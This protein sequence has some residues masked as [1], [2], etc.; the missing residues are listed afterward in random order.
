[1][2]VRRSLRDL[3]TLTKKLKNRSPEL[4]QVSLHASHLPADDEI[5]AIADAIM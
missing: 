2:F 5:N 1:M 3:T 4:K